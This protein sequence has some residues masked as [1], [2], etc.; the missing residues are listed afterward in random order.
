MAYPP[1]LSEEWSPEGD[2][3]ELIADILVIIEQCGRGEAY[4]V[5]RA[6]GLE[7]DGYSLD[8]TQQAVFERRFR[9]ALGIPQRGAD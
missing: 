3:D 2:R 5:R 4:D 6:L 7:S 9:E 1:A 8:N